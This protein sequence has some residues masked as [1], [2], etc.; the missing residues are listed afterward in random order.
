MFI[1]CILLALSSAIDAFG[2][3]I[4]Y[5]LKNIRVLFTA[6]II[7][8]TCL[9]IVTLLGLLLGNCLSSILPNN[10][11]GIIGSSVL[12]F[13]GILILFSSFKK[14]NDF[15]LD[16]SNNI[17]NKEVLLLCLAFSFDSFG[18]GLSSFFLKAPIFLLPLF[19]AL[20]HLIFLSIGILLGSK[21][22]KFSKIPERIWNI[23]SGLLLILIGIVKLVS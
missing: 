19:V 15:D 12:I 22:K 17:D 6:K 14:E 21:I 5:G 10:I 2:I 18:I 1:V 8:F 16:H 20:F 4:T 9:F 23:I 11:T 3:G 13:I 7:L